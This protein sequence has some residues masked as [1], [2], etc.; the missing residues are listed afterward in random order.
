MPGVLLIE[1]M[2]QTSGWLLIALHQVRPHAVPRRREGGQAAHLRHA[3]PGARGV[4]EDRARRLGL[5]AD[6][7]RD[8][9]ATARPSA[10]PSSRSAWSISRTG[11]FRASM[12]EVARRIAFPMEACRR[13]L[14]R[15][16]RP[17]SPA[18]A[19]SRASARARTR[20]GRRSAPAIRSADA[21]HLRALRRASARAARLRQADPEEGRPAPDGAVAA[22][23]HLCRGPRARRRRRQRQRRTPGA[24]R[25]DRRRRRRRARHRGRHRDPVR[26]APARR[27]R[28]PS[29]TSG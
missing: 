17:G 13:W 11:E 6:R 18:S 27:S 23:R 10:T 5:R 24:H 19:S 29:S 1:T 7:G 20:I 4:G 15:R 16:A 3:G 14:T 25:H 22:H 2:A 28:R 9:G 26:L 21:D 8:Q 12:E